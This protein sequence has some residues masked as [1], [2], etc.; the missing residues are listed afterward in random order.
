MIMVALNIVAT[1]YTIVLYFTKYEAYLLNILNY[2]GLEEI[3]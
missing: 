3:S 2:Y 1:I